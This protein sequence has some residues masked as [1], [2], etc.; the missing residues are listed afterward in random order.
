MFLVYYGSAPVACQAEFGP[1][2]ETPR[3]LLAGVRRVSPRWLRDEMK[4]L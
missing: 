4:V 3:A 2:D 1:A